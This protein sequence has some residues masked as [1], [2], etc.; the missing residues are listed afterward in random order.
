MIYCSIIVE[1]D[2]VKATKTLE[3]IFLPSEFFNKTEPNINNRR[4]H[5]CTRA[6]VIRSTVT[7]GIPSSERVIVLGDRGPN[8]TLESSSESLN[9]ARGNRSG[10]WT[11]SV[12]ATPSATTYGSLGGI[13]GSVVSCPGRVAAARS[14]LLCDAAISGIAAIWNVQGEGRRG[15]RFTIGRGREDSCEF[16]FESEHSSLEVVYI[17]NFSEHFASAMQNILWRDLVR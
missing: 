10:R 8:I 14:S 12:V 9:G 7:I 6:M 4:G 3:G 15:E 17:V 2:V 11:F 13:I 5:H 1:N 16:T